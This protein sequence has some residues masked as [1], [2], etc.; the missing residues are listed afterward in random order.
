MCKDRKDVPKCSN[1]EP[2]DM[3]TCDGSIDCPHGFLCTP[4]AKEREKI[5]RYR[6]AMKQFN[7]PDKVVE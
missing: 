1:G 6:W 4:E 5:K 3:E 7:K 2:C